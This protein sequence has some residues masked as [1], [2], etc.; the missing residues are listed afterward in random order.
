MKLISI[1]Y[2]LLPVFLIA[3]VKEVENEFKG[4]EYSSVQSIIIPDAGVLV[5][6]AHSSKDKG[7][8]SFSTDFTFYGENLEKKWE[9]SGVISNSFTMEEIKEQ[10]DLKPFSEGGKKRIILAFEESYQISLDGKHL[11][12]VD[13]INNGNFYHISLISG[14]SQLIELDIPSDE[15]LIQIK[16][17]I[18]DKSFYMVRTLESEGETDKM[19]YDIFTTDLTTLKTVKTNGTTPS[20]NGTKYG[21]TTTIRYWDIIGIGIDGL[22]LVDNYGLEDKENDKIYRRVLKI[23]INGEVLIDAYIQ[24]SDKILYDG[25]IGDFYY[26]QFGNGRFYTF[27]MSKKDKNKSLIYCEYD[28]EFNLIWKETVPTEII[29]GKGDF[30]YNIF[31][32]YNSGA[33]LTMFQADTHIHQSIDILG[34]D[35]A[36]KTSL[37]T[38]N[39]HKK[40]NDDGFYNSG[41]SFDEYILISEYPK[42]MDYVKK[43]TADYGKKIKLEFSFRQLNENEL[44]VVALPKVNGFGKI[45]KAFFRAASFK[46]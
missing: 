40:F 6:T 19:N 11:F 15:K 16:C 33:T 46:I 5:M 38:K 34:S 13:Q 28:K 17:G 22:F 12:I 39:D 35:K 32:K 9:K 27:S 7:S 45:D 42:V 3:Q 25:H 14:E 8:F 2:L 10:Y 31:Q 18:D 21:L 41:L 30:S 37:L 4:K 29:P 1:L 26:N 36:R 20:N 23:A 24:I 44:I 43:L